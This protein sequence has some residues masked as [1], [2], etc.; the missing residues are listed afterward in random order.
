MLILVCNVGSTSLKYKLFDM[1]SPDIL[2]EGKVERVGRMDAIFTYKNNKNGFSVRL[3]NI[4]IPDYAAG[5]N[6]FLNY[7]LGDAS[8]VVDDIGQLDAIGFKTVVSKGYY[9]IHELTDDVIKAM[10]EYISVAPAHN[11]PISRRSRYSGRS[12]L[13]G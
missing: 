5:I 9:G 8:G 7:L 10:E 3:D 1:P 2:A 4:S 13:N 11:L 6:V 12:F